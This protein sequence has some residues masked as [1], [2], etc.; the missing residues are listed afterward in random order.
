MHR[1]RV[2][3]CSIRYS[4]VHGRLRCELAS[5]HVFRPRRCHDTL[6]GTAARHERHSPNTC[7][8]YGV[9]LALPTCLIHK[10][11]TALQQ[12]RPLLISR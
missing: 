12:P 11:A 7:P 2:Q 5:M 4:M 10:P 6:V 9:N 1:L 8:G 3:L